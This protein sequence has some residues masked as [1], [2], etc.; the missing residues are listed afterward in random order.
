M[1]FSTVYCLQIDYNKGRG[2]PP[3]DVGR[4]ER[5]ARWPSS[6]QDFGFNNQKSDVN[7]RTEAKHQREADSKIDLLDGISTPPKQWRVDLSTNTSQHHSIISTPSSGSH[8]V[9]L[10]ERVQDS[11][12]SVAQAERHTDTTGQTLHSSDLSQAS[13]SRRRGG[14][15]SL[16]PHCNTVTNGREEGRNSANLSFGRTLRDQEAPNND[17]DRATSRSQRLSFEDTSSSTLAETA[18]DLELKRQCEAEEA[19]AASLR[20]KR[21]L[22]AAQRRAMEEEL[23][24]EEKA[25]FNKMK[26]ELS[27]KRK[28][29]ARE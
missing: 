21:L 27:M 8:R 17:S 10:K 9:G 16:H 22:M 13:T 28:M 3:I 18:E 12:V 1:Q 7:H 29:I 26:Q 20:R 24:A 6:M 2:S 4:N 23:L 14:V 15:V 25:A 19:R 5:R 11:P